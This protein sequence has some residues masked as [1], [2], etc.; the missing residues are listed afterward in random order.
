M[1]TR[2]TKKKL[3]GRRFNG[4]RRRGAG[5][6][7]GIPWHLKNGKLT[8]D[9]AFM[10]E[11]III[12]QFRHGQRRRI[13]TTR[14]SLTLYRLLQ[15]ASER[16]IY[17]WYSRYMR[18]EDRLD[19]VKSYGQMA[20]KIF[21]EYKYLMRREKSFL[22][23]MRTEIPRKKRF[24]VLDRDLQ[25]SLKS[26]KKIIRKQERQEKALERAIR[27]SKKPVLQPKIP[28]PRKRTPAE[29]E[30]QRALVY[31]NELDFYI[32]ENGRK[33]WSER[34]AQRKNAIG[35]EKYFRNKEKLEQYKR[36]IQPRIEE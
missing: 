29:I 18:L 25:Q 35:A 36:G 10:L 20:D 14:A 3:D 5:R 13:K 23:L 30:R 24:P 12:K 21:T 33:V 26:F 32:D 9:Q 19:R 27:I 16:E 15:L 4:G 8:Y 2:K 28:R 22:Q 1:T 34:A 6:P 31:K 7:R 17:D 11:P